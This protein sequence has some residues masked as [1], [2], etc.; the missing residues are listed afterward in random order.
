MERVC[1]WCLM[2]LGG[3]VE[4]GIGVGGFEFEFG[5]VEAFVI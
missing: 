5:E 2:V 4:S 1:R 3:G